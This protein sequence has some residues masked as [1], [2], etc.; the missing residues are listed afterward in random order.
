M[1]ASGFMEGDHLNKA[2]PVQQISLLN[3]RYRRLS[4]SPCSTPSS[5]F[6]VRSSTNSLNPSES[7]ETPS[8]G[9]I[10]SS[11][12]SDFSYNMRYEAE[13]PDELALVKAASAYGCRLCQRS[14]EKVSVYLPGLFLNFCKALLLLLFYYY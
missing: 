8:E 6:R 4:E 14:P 9:S 12:L 13:S 7:G 2:K 3:E 1:D 10:S 11:C 5:K